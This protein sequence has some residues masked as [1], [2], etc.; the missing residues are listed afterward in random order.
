[1]KTRAVVMD[2]NARYYGVR[3]NDD[4][5]LPHNDARMGSMRYV[6]WLNRSTAN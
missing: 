3:L 2:D 4:M 6:D 1:M 5:L